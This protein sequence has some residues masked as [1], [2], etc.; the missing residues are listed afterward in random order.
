MAYTDHKISS[1]D[2][3]GRDISGLPDH[4]VGQAAML[5]A[6]FDALTK[7]LV[8]PRFNAL[9]TELAG[10]E[11]AEGIGTGWKDK[12]L[13][14]AVLSED[15]RE[16]T[17]DET[18]RLSVSK[19]EDVWLTVPAGHTVVDAHGVERRSTTKLQFL[20]SDVTVTG[21]T[22]VIKPLGEGGGLP[23]RD[24]LS[25]FDE[26]V[27]GGYTGSQEEF[28]KTLARLPDIVE[29]FEG[30]TAGNYLRNSDFSNPW[31]TLGQTSYEGTLSRC[32]DHWA[33]AAPTGGVLTVEP[34]G[35]V[36][37]AAGYAETLTQE[38]RELSHLAGKT[39]CF[40]VGGVPLSEGAAF[41]AQLKLTLGG[42][43]SMTAF[44]GAVDG[45]VGSDCRAVV[46]MKL[47]ETLQD[48][49][50]L[51]ASIRC[52]NVGD[53]VRFCWAKLEEGEGATQFKPV[54]PALLRL[55]NGPDIG[56]QVGSF[57]GDSTE[58]G[59][60]R[61]IDCGFT[62]SAV[63]MLVMGDNWYTG[64]DT[65]M[66]RASAYIALATKAQPYNSSDTLEAV[67]IVE[68]GFAVTYNTWSEFNYSGA[69]T[70]YIAFR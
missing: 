34:E 30:L 18:G 52:D 6:R 21:D 62:P 36:M 43:D 51:E 15:V 7:E 2:Y 59:T 42:A 67:K 69:R 41:H 16:I 66:Y 54:E 24:G 60:I 23:G 27:A 11:G 31:N 58:A 1:V 10:G 13:G 22:T 12:T 17:A 50:V 29:E 4:V 25:A 46:T 64:E 38:L 35:L 49:H 3:T 8:V 44:S 19:E 61:V 57:T 63:L 68:G 47:P 45:E 5:K 55:V 48:S 40:S 70:N 65:P 9:L 37:T 28:D 53:K 26:A 56:Y 20:N 14:R 39:V 32:I 33:L